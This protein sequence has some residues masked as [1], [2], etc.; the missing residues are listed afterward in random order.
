MVFLGVEASFS[1]LHHR[2]EKMKVA[3][4][5]CRQSEESYKSQFLENEKLCAFYQSQVEKS[6]EK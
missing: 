2:F 1:N 5:Q 4:E 6:A 3:L